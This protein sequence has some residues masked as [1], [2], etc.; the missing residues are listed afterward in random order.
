MTRAGAISARLAY[1]WATTAQVRLGRHNPL[2]RPRRSVAA[3]RGLGDERAG[4]VGCRCSE[5]GSSRN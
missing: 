4:A 5:I 1:L 3:K 2:E